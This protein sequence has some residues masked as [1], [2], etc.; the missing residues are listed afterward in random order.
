VLD[1]QDQ[2]PRGIP[3]RLRAR[4]G[5]RS[6]RTSCPRAIP[7]LWATRHGIPSPIE[8]RESNAALGN[9]RIYGVGNLNQSSRLRDNA[10][11]E[12]RTRY[13]RI[14]ERNQ[15]FAVEE[16]NRYA[17]SFSAR[18]RH[19]QPWAAPFRA[20][21]PGIVKVEWLSKSSS[22]HRR[23]MIASVSPRIS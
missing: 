2:R 22:V 20:G 11:L 7:S 18:Q 13:P 5:T 23:L 9:Y 16:R 10:R 14:L 12:R 19:H 4:R 15:L 1:A 8:R 21:G 3:R 17:R 6:P